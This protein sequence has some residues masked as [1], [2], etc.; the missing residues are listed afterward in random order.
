MSEVESG[1][2]GELVAVGTGIRAVGQLTTEAIAWM[3]RADR[4]LYILGDAVAEATVRQLNPAGAESLV[5][6]YQ[7]GV[8]RLRTY[9]AMAERILDCV[10]GGMVTCVASYGHPGIFADPIHLAVRRAREEGYSAQ[11]LPAVSSEDCLFAELGIDPAVDGCQSFDATDFLLHQRMLD[12]TAGA[13][14]WQIGVAGDPLYRRDGYDLSL[15]PKVI[16]RLIRFHP[17]AHVVTVYEASIFPGAAPVIRATRLDELARVPLSSA[18]TLYV[19]PSRPAE[20]DRSVL[21]W[22]ESLY[23]AGTA[24]VE[25]SGDQT[26]RPVTPSAGDEFRDAAASH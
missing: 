26:G 21:R 11:I 10:R 2:V 25:S 5:S 24:L 7:E 4:L 1:K 17:P 18:S 20:V 9:H 15:L 6:F 19:P 13:V 8:P 12:P 16:D 22:I 3:R 14:I 23:T